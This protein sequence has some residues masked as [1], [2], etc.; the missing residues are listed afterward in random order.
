MHQCLLAPYPPLLSLCS[1][2]WHCDRCFE[3]K[4]SVGGW[5]GGLFCLITGLGVDEAQCDYCITCDLCEGRVG[6]CRYSCEHHSV[7]ASATPCLRGDC[8]S[9]GTPSHA[10]H[11]AGQ[12]EE[13]SRHGYCS[14]AFVLSAV[15]M[16]AP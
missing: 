1:P 7:E 9:H 2:L 16:C 4:V 12:A 13:S 10:H 6:H 5:R 8:A 15:V 14:P 11:L 3:L